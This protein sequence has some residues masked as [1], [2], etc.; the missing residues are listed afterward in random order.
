M[1][2]T[3]SERNRKTLHIETE[4]EAKQ[5]IGKYCAKFSG[6]P[7]KSGNLVNKITGVGTF[8]TSDNKKKIA[9]V[10]DED[11]TMVS[12]QMVYIVE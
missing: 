7:F 2:L 1:R 5:Y 9:F 8:V 4:D 11:G 12:Y 10:F 6:K 3:K